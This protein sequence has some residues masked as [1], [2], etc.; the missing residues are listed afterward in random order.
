MHIITFYFNTLIEQTNYNSTSNIFENVIKDKEKLKTN[1]S[2]IKQSLLSNKNQI[3]KIIHS[4]LCES[5]LEIRELMCLKS[6]LSYRDVKRSMQF[7]ILFFKKLVKVYLR[8]K[9]E[10]DITKDVLKQKI[11]PQSIV[12]SMM[13]SIVFRFSNETKIKAVTDNPEYEQNI[14]DRCE[15]FGLKREFSEDGSYFKISIRSALL[16]RLQKIIRI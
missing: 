3:L 12:L 6:I 2:I 9:G 16:K 4:Y 13:I 1:L 11:I 5:F 10:P 14:K 7:F 8:K 15:K